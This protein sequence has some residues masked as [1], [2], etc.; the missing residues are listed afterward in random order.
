MCETGPVLDGVRAAWSLIVVEPVVDTDA[1]RLLLPPRRSR[2]AEPGR[3]RGRQSLGARA[4]AA[5]RLR[6]RIASS[7]AHGRVFA[8]SAA[9][10]HARRAVAMP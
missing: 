6:L 10:S 4:H 3:E 7:S 8:T 2:R 5:E 1:P 9:V